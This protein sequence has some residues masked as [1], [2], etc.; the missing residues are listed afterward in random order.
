MKCSRCGAE[1]PANM[2]FCGMCGNAVASP[3][4]T[5]DEV[6][7]RHCVSCGRALAWDA[8]VCQY[9]GHDFRVQ[10]K[11]KDQSK[12]SLVVGGVL[13]ILAGVFSLV[14]TTLIVSEAGRM[15]T[16]SGG[17]V[18]LIY[19]CAVLGLLGGLLALARK[20]FPISVLGAACS[21]FGPGFFFGI[22]GLALI[23]RGSTLF[24][25]REEPP[26]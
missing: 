10:A 4:V 11:P 22:P 14:L 5:P 15:D 24:A 16:A 26:K 3:V 8:N 25:G 9:C 20:S 13:T 12:D 21:V 6:R 7:I 23:V 18:A 19:G 17:F 2:K 1:N